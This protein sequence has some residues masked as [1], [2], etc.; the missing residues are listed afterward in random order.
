M[1]KKPEKIKHKI[2]KVQTPKDN[3]KSSALYQFF[4][5]LIS[6]AICY[7]YHSKILPNLFNEKSTPE[8]ENP[9][10]LDKAFP[11]V[12]QYKKNSEILT[13]SDKISLQCANNYKPVFLSKNPEVKSK[14]VPAESKNCGRFFT[15]GLEENILTDTEVKTLQKMA[16]IGTLVFNVGSGGPSI[17]EMVSGVASFKN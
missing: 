1:A 4:A 11:S 14:C 9:N 15:N 3:G 6:S 16:E 5:L 2:K 10:R 8:V 17:I 12:K 7:Y 13:S